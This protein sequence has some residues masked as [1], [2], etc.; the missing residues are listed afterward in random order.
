[1]TGPARPIGIN[2]LIGL[3]ILS[4]VSFAG[5]RVG[6]T[7]TALHLQASTFTVGMILSLLAMLPMLLAI[8]GGR[9]VD[10]IGVRW[11]MIGGV[12][13]V[14]T[15]VLL[16][17]AWP[18]IGVLYVTA[19]LVGL[20]YLPFHLGAQKLVADI[21]SVE[22]RRH[23]YSLYAIGFSVS[24][25]IGPTLVGFLIDAIGHRL[26]FGVLGMLSVATLTWL[27]LRRAALPDHGGG[28]VDTTASLRIWD[29]LRTPDLRRLYV[30]VALISSAWDVHQFLVPIYGA[31]I[32]LSASGIGLILG[33]FSV[34]TLVVRLVVPLFLMNVSEWR[35]IMIAQS[36]AA[37]VY[38][39]YPLFSTL[40]S[41][42]AM[43]F[44][45]GLGLGA[46]QPMTLSILARS[47]PASRL[48]EATGLRM[49]LVNGTQTVLPGTFGALGGLL[50][51]AP[52]F[53]AMAALLA[54]GAGSLGRF[55][56]RRG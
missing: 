24:G 1:V 16:P 6:L 22:D 8:P 48:G 4:H 37:G 49:T 54:G 52:L 17:L 42:L 5:A 25:F 36:I 20:G 7:L 9:W 23:H 35:V 38:A 51:V 12:A 40:E 56:H 53:W 41:M 21:G 18:S 47:A 46:S 26:A 11:P 14:M 13:L 29:L 28:Q 44:L 55:L 50:G 19:M 30:V 27:N 45:L 10:R 2:E 15:G 34:A 43:S 31:R 3:T 32:G 39:F 33:A